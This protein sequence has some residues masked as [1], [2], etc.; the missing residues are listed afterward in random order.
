MVIDSNPFSMCTGYMHNRKLS[1]LSPKDSDPGNAPKLKTER[2]QAYY[3]FFF[4]KCFQH[5]G[6][7]SPSGL[8]KQPNGLLHTYTHTTVD[9]DIYNY[10]YI[11]ED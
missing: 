3:F 1:G 10:P 11:Q 2:H 4:K 9:N 6:A 5:M 8:T 7:E